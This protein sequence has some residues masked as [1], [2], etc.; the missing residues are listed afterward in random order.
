MARYKYTQESGTT[1]KVNTSDKADAYEDTNEIRQILDDLGELLGH[2]KFD[3]AYPKDAT[4]GGEIDI[5]RVTTKSAVATL[6]T[7]EAGFVK[8][9]AAAGYSLTLPTAVGNKLTYIFVKTDDNANLITIDGHSTETINGSLTYTDLNY[10]YAYVAIRSDNA[11]WY[12]LFRSRPI[13]IADNNLV[14]ID[15]ATV[16]DNDFAKFTANGLEGRSYAEV[17]TDISLNNV[18]N[19]K[20]KLDATSAPTVN[21]D[22]DEGY[23]VGSIWCDVTNDKAYVCLDN[24]DGAAVWTETTA[25]ASAVDTSGTPVD[26]DF[27]KFTDAD[28]IEGRSYNEV[29]TDLGLV[30]GTNVLAEQTIGIANDNLMEV[31]DADAADNDYAKFTANGLEG[32]SAAEAKTDLSFITDVIDDTT[33]ELGGEMDCGAHSIGFTQQTVSY[34]VTTTTVDWRLSNKATMTFG[35]GNIGTFA[36]TNP[37]NPCN[38]VLKIIQDGTGSRVV[39]AWDA[40]IKWV[41]GSAPTLTTGAN[42]IDVISFYWDGTNFFGA[43]SLAFS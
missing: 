2:S 9:S 21:N 11:N 12:V 36:F 17:K 4:S 6:T 20:V 28:T 24:T 7:A 39:T 38:V 1:F 10:Q 8:V 16:A 29:R 27:A 19:L 15:H 32:R 3:D 23:A 13:G 33:P 37:T 18:E 43:A 5:T 41:G 34:N 14:E 26:N 42:T 40:D 30:I 22:V 35:A 25:G 31:D